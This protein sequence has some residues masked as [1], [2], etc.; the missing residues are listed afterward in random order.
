[1]SSFRETK[2]T[3]SREVTTE[4]MKSLGE[5]EKTNKLIRL[6]SVSEQ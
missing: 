3:R 1:M 4:R 5:A 2:C 6:V